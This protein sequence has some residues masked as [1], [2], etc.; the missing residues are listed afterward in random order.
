MFGSAESEKS[1]LS[2]SPKLK[3]KQA[4]VEAGQL[5]APPGGQITAP[6]GGSTE[7]SDGGPL[8]SDLVAKQ[9]LPA[10]EEKVVKERTA[11]VQGQLSFSS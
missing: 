4:A 11:Q 1:Q 5:V 3:A 10:M 2:S 7:P 8:P 6:T 9:P